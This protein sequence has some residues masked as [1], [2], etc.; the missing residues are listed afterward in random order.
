[1]SPRREICRVVLVLNHSK[2]TTG[3][4]WLN[5]RVNSEKSAMRVAQ[6]GTSRRGCTGKGAREGGRV[7]SWGRRGSLSGRAPASTV[8]SPVR[9]FDA[10][11]DERT[12]TSKFSTIPTLFSITSFQF[13]PSPVLHW[14]RFLSGIYCILFR[15]FCAPELREESISETLERWVFDPTENL[16]EKFVLK[17]DRD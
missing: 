11:W 5:E 13:V 8:F 10:I 9:H 2:R 14:I 1:M 3:H 4:S 12:R 15:S 16:C 17:R 7:D 6:C